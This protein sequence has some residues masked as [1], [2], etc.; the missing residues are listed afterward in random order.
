MPLG[1]IQWLAS[2][3]AVGGG[4]GVSAIPRGGASPALLQLVLALAREAT[5]NFQP[6][7]ALEKVG[8]L[9]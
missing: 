3:V 2:S 5:F 4:L 7:G 8:F 6:V 1:D 9:E